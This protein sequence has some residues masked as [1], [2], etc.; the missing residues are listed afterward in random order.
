MVVRNTRVPIL[1]AAGIAAVLTPGSSPAGEPV[2]MPAIA[3]YQPV[4]A[5]HD[6]DAKSGDV[7]SA[8]GRFART[9]PVPPPEA[10]GSAV[11]AGVGRSGHAAAV[12]AAKAVRKVHSSPGTVR[13]AGVGNTVRE[14]AARSTDDSR[15]TDRPYRLVAGVALPEADRFLL[16]VEADLGVMVVARDSGRGVHDS[17]ILGI[18]S[19]I[20]QFVLSR[21]L[22]GGRR[23]MDT[24]ITGLAGT[25]ADSAGNP[26]PPR[27][28]AD[29]ADAKGGL[30]IPPAWRR[31]TGTEFAI[32]EAIAGR[33]SHFR[34]AFRGVAD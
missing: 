17:S 13:A 12:P 5:P 34:Q 32:T 9:S 25:P 15:P 11:S 19:A 7:F 3:G 14:P 8:L 1:L 23:Y 16:G 30:P 2:G 28:S 29:P 33:V 4:R 24:P 20:G 18:D 21:S 10:G 31:L 26:P 27:W 6:P 22:D